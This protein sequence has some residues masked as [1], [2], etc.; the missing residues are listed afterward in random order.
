[1]MLL[2]MELFEK[3]APRDEVEAALKARGATAR[4]AAD[5]AGQARSRF[6]NEVLRSTS[7]PTS[8]HYDV[9]YY[10]LLGVT[11]TA[12]TERIRRSYRRK[13]KE[14]HPDRH[15]KEFTREF[16]VQLMVMVSDANEV[17]TDPARRRAYDLIWRDRSEKVAAENKRNGEDR[18]DWETH[19]RLQ[20]AELSELE[21]DMA[22]QID[23][24]K[25]ATA[26]GAPIDSAVSTLAE[27][28]ENYEG[29]ILGIRA[30][31]HTSRPQYLRFGETVRY[32]MQRKERLVSGLKD[33]VAWLPQAQST[34]TPAAMASRIAAVEQVMLA[35]R[36]AQNQFDISGLR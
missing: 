27:S 33:L 15:D 2:A 17:L 14:Y 11:P 4:E 29:D 28:L 12:S 20:M 13:A 16:W 25:T 6:E 18:G 10:F 35:V 31:T 22:E 23:A 36:A 32:E 8:A 1:M 19:N 9:N 3:D 30:E 26:A 5:V 7:L 21:D 34:E 24:I